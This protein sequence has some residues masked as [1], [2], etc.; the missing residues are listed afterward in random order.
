[1][2]HNPILKVLSTFQSFEIQALLMGGQACV[3][4]GAAEFS[5][6]TDFAVLHSEENLATLRRGLQALDAEPVFF[7]PLEAAYLRKGHACHFRARHPEARG[8]RIDI[9]SV[10]RGCDPFEVLWSRRQLIDLPGLPGVPLLSLPDLVCAKRTQRDKDWPMIR[11]L[12][13]VDYMS[14]RANPTPEKLRFWARESRTPR[15]L[16]EIAAS[17]PEIIEGE[18]GA[19]PL[20]ALAKVGTE[21]ALDRAL[22]E[23]QEHERALDR[24]YWRPLRAELE[25]LRRGRAAR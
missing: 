20:L 15:D 16:L 6:D 21:E 8:L 14:H 11:R 19:R 13:E 24:E 1:L 22:L 17:A 2:I 4:L 10:L 23:E 5:R 25:A 3:L 7:P 18:L 9:M 12:L